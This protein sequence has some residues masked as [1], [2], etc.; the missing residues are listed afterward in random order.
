[1]STGMLNRTDINVALVICVRYNND[2]RGSK[3]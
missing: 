3:Y 1:M 2:S